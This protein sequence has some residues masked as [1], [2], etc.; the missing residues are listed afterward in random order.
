[1]KDIFSLIFYIFLIE[2][3][4]SFGWE[5]KHKD[6]YVHLMMSS[7]FGKFPRE[8]VYG[9]P[10]TNAYLPLNSWHA[11][12]CESLYRTTDICPIASQLCL[13]IYPSP[14][15]QDSSFFK[16]CHHTVFTIYSISD[17]FSGLVWRVDR[18]GGEVMKSHSLYKQN[19]KDHFI[20]NRFQNP[21]LKWLHL[22]GIF[23]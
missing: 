11:K 6:G 15:F 5:P 3:Q 13:I 19:P 9:H 7:C 22:L 8:R 17:V 4:D 16:C 10:I 21:S 18:V 14:Q 1:M 12:K 20:C 23:F 2:S